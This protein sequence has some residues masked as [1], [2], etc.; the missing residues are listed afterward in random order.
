MIR[1]SAGVTAV[2]TRSA[3]VDVHGDPVGAPST[4]QIGPGGIDYNAT[5]S[6]Q[7]FQD[8]QITDVDYWVPRGDD[9]V[10]GDRVTL[11]GRS[12]SVQGVPG[13][14]NQNHPMSGHDFGFKLVRLREVSGA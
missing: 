6:N 9:V 7:Q 12:Y 11:A 14:W 5:S 2:V 8:V 13:L 4:H 1:L 3:G 10:E